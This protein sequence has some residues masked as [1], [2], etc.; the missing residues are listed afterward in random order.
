MIVGVDETGSLR[1]S[2]QYIG[3]G[4]TDPV[5]DGRLQA[6]FTPGVS[7]LQSR[8]QGDLYVTAH[9]AQS[10]LRPMLLRTDGFGGF[11]LAAEYVFPQL[12]E[13]LVAFTDIVELPPNVPGNTA[14]YAVS[15]SVLR[16]T[17]ER[18]VVLMLTD[19]QLNPLVV[20][21]YDALTVKEG[22]QFP[23][24]ATGHGITF[25]P[26]TNLVAIAGVTDLG[27]A[28]PAFAPFSAPH[29]LT[30]DPL[31]NF[32]V[33]NWTVFDPTGG[34]PF[35]PGV[36]L[37]TWETDY[38][39][40]RALSNADEP[41]VVV[42]GTFFDPDGLR[43]AA[44]FVTDVFGGLRWSR[45]YV[46]ESVGRSAVRALDCGVAVGGTFVGVPGAA[47]ANPFAPA[48]EL[49]VKTNDAGDAACFDP[50]VRLV[51][52]PIDF[53]AFAFEAVPNFLD[54]DNDLIT[55][56]IQTGDGDAICFDPD[57]EPICPGDINGDNKVDGSDLVI[58]LGNFGM[59]LPGGASVGDFDNS[60]TV[61]G[62]DLVFFLANFGRMCP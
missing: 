13:G 41:R 32:A 28:D 17:G 59:M 5:H 12:G 50:E 19:P 34:A 62:A 21:V 11:V 47:P 1:F 52:F 54:G 30:L 29:V 27:V 9:N 49:L 56:P 14:T 24:S 3:T 42:G 16:P 40:V 33:V 43:Q 35:E 39:S 6:T 15:G 25:D 44:A 48:A 26:G 53:E 20:R 61:D 2:R 10:G 37:P 60:G 57:C 45:G 51:P 4:F 18:D 36:P 46:D 38:A 8:E 31:A 58:L 23:A 7:L 22:A 55:D